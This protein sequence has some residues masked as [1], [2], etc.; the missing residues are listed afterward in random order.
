MQVKHC[1]STAG[2]ACK[3]NGGGAKCNEIQEAHLSMFKEAEV[4]Y[5]PVFPGIRKHF[6]KMKILSVGFPNGH[7]LKGVS[8]RNHTS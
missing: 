3:E 6:V 8:H 1:K 4:P 5:I 7:K 2:S